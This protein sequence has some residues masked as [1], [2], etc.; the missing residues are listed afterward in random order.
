MSH[1]LTGQNLTN[2]NYVS[3]NGEFALDD[4]SRVEDLVGLGRAEAA[5]RNVAEVVERAFINGDSVEPFIP[6]NMK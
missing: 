3:R 2:V 6:E 5:K 4:A 1:L